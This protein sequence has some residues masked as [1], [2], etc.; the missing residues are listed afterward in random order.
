MDQNAPGTTIRT[1]D[2][3][4]RLISREIA[5]EQIVEHLHLCPFAADKVS[6]RLRNVEI[7]MGRLIG[8]LLGSGAL[9]GAA[10]AIVH[11][12]LGK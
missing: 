6:D 5:N 4:V 7:S 2:E 3:R 1:D 12:L 8:F 10:G 9:G 11:A